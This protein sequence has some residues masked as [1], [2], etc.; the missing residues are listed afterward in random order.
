MILS[1]LCLLVL[2]ATT[3]KKEGAD[4]HK[5]ITIINNSNQDVIPAFK[6]TD[7]NN[8]CILSGSAIKPGESYKDDRKEC[9]ENK[10][11]ATN[12]YDVYIVDPVQYNPPNVFYSCDAIEIKNKA[13][14]H[15]VLTLDDLKK[16]DFTVTYP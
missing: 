16:T 13:L 3:C 15:Y 10:I 2:S 7:P 6:F 1:I 11:S 12:P 5:T 8:K 4:C 14:K 9:W